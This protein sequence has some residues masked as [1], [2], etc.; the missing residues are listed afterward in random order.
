[1]TSADRHL[2]ENDSDIAALI[3]SESGRLERFSLLLCETI[4]RRGGRYAGMPI[5]SFKPRPGPPLAER[6]LRG[7]AELGVIHLEGAFNSGLP[8]LGPANKPYIAAWA[9]ASLPYERLVVL[10]SDLLMLGEPVEFALPDGVTVAVAPEPLKLAGTNGAD[11]NAA[12]WDAYQAHLGITSNAADIVTLVDEQRI[13]GYYNSGCVVVR[14]DA[15]LIQ[16]WLEAM[17][18]LARSGLVPGDNRA[19]FTEQIALSLS[20]AK[21][22]LEPKILPASHNYPLPWH[23]QLPARTR[24][25]SLNEI[26]IAHYHDMFDQPT[27]GNP[28]RHIKGL[29]VTDGDD[30]EIAALLHSTGVTPDPRSAPIRSL[31]VAARARVVPIAKRMGLRPGRFAKMVKPGAQAAED[32]GQG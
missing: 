28:L 12:M 4:R 25:G 27:T 30:D 31:R 14:R 20:I 21:L 8:G 18:S 23:R 11:E 7:F 32:A 17:E 1:M 24:V 22:G 29:P 2:H 15:G 13:R 6:T 9:E 19:F 26:V 16:V 10:D 5:F 3:C